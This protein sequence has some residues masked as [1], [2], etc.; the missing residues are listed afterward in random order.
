VIQVSQQAIDRVPLI[1]RQRGI[2][3]AQA[4]LRME[5]TQNNKAAEAVPIQ[6]SE[7][8]TCRQD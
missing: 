3:E 7:Q 2:L 8:G 5:A 6:V 1:E 4:K